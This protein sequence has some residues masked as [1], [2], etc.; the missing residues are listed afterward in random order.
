FFRS[1]IRRVLGHYRSWSNVLAPARPLLKLR[2]RRLAVQPFS[3]PR[4]LFV[5]CILAHV[6]PGRELP[7]AVVI[8]G[9]IVDG[10]R[11]VSWNLQRWMRD[12]TPCPNHGSNGRINV[13][14]EP[15]GPHDRV[16]IVS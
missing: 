15:V 7:E 9:L 3:C 16:F 2:A 4:E 10:E 6:S 8:A 1:G 12:L 14:N 5:R 11:A 13:G